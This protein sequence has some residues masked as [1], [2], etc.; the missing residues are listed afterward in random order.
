MGLAKPFFFPEEVIGTEK[1]QPH[2]FRYVQTTGTP[3]SMASS[4]WSSARD[5]FSV[6]IRQEDFISLSLSHT[7]KLYKVS[8]KTEKQNVDVV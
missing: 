3:L 8:N 6:A 1:A 4:D 2:D 7:N 5:I